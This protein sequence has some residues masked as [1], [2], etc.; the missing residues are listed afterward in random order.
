METTALIPGPAAVPALNQD[1]TEAAAALVTD[2]PSG[3]QDA[4]REIDLEAE[5]AAYKDRLENPPPPEPP[6]EPEAPA[7]PEAPVE[8]ET[9]ETVDTDPAPAH[10]GTRP[11]DPQ[12]RL[13]PREGSTDMEVARL[14]KAGMTFEEAVDFLRQKRTETPA[15]APDVP[16]A[17]TPAAGTVAQLESRR[18]EVKAAMKQATLDYELEKLADLQAELADLPF[19]IFEARQQERA[20]QV[21]QQSTAEKAIAEA[22][23][24]AMQLY[25]DIAV[26]NSE[27]RVEMEV[28]A[29]ALTESGDPLLTQPDCGLRIAQMAARNLSIAP[30]TTAPKSVSPQRPAPEPAKAPNAVRPRPV[31]GSGAAS[32]AAPVV[33]V[34]QMTAADFDAARVAYLKN[35]GQSAY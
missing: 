24:R 5:L 31:M 10:P 34:S 7:A 14:Q 2:S 33:D 20:V 22:E 30:V 23:A 8:E 1:K 15:A 27:M 3:N 6:A 4:P 32:Q 17:V 29:A 35:L 18:A 26:E 28:I 21:E 25:P 19:Q 11:K 13:R 12:V 16:A 9:D